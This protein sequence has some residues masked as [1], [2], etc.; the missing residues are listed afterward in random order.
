MRYTVDF[1]NIAPDTVEVC[2][3]ETT[4]IAGLAV[5]ADAMQFVFLDNGVKYVAPRYFVTE[6]ADTGDLEALKSRH[7][8]AHLLFDAK[9]E[10]FALVSWT[11]PDGPCWNG[12]MIV[13]L[14]DDIAVVTRNDLLVVGKAA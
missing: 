13:P 9:A 11:H 7:P 12:K 10:T 8:D 14:N 4:D 3:V 2:K 1:M 5:P 6:E